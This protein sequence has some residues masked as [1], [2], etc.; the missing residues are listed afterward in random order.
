M[1]IVAHNTESIM[2]EKHLFKIFRYCP[3][4]QI[5]DGEMT[6]TEARKFMDEN[7]TFE[8]RVGF[9]VFND[10]LNRWE[11][12]KDSYHGG[13]KVYDNKGNLNIIDPDYRNMWSTEN[14]GWYIWEVSRGRRFII[15]LGTKEKAEE[16]C[17]RYQKWY[18]YESDHRQ[19]IVEPSDVQIKEL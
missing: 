18:D 5:F 16:V 17:A 10:A 3:L 8:R 6:F 11:D 7:A 1:E 9:K 15:S 12:F 14:C 13:R 4:E 19:Y 2:E